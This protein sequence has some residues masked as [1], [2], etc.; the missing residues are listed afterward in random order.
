MST[1]VGG[2]GGRLCAAADMSVD[3][4]GGARPARRPYGVKRGS[5]QEARSAAVIQMTNGGVC[6]GIGTKRYLLAASRIF[7]PWLT[8]WVGDELPDRHRPQFSNEQ[9]DGVWGQGARGWIWLTTTSFQSRS[10]PGLQK[11]ARLPALRRQARHQ[12]RCPVNLP[13]GSCP[14]LRPRSRSPP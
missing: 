1:D 4:Q 9:R 7:L 3:R 6:I 13:C 8:R 11:T 10:L 5:H 2:K 12:T 14:R